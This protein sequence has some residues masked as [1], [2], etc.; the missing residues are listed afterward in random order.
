M[1]IEI[2]AVKGAKIW[3]QRVDV[4]V[5]AGKGVESHSKEEI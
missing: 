2:K 4:R 3:T 5:E 1:D